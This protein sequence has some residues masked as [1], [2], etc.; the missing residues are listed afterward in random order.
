[1]NELGEQLAELWTVYL[2]SIE[3]RQRHQVSVSVGDKVLEV[4]NATFEGMLNWLIE[5]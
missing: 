1:M 4:R 3:E 2:E 5:Q